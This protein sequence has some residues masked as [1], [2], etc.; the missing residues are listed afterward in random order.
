MTGLFRP[1]RA[2][3]APEGESEGTH[4]Q[5]APTADSDFYALRA[6][7]AKLTIPHSATVV[8][9]GGH[10]SWPALFS[11]LSGVQSILITD[12]GRVEALDIGR[13]PY[14][15]Q[16]VGRLKTD[17]LEDVIRF[18]RPNI[19]ILKNNRRLEPPESDIFHG[20]VL[21][22]GVDYKPLEEW[23]PDAARERSMKYV[24]GFYF[25]N[26]VG[27][28]NE[29]LHNLQY[30]RGIQVPVW[31]GSAAMSGCL[32]VMAAFAR[33]VTSGVTCKIFPCPLMS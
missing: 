26:K 11:A 25:G 27:V 17:A 10:G 7:V 19:E 33:P 29:Q 3:A 31:S 21:F 12:M 23:L 30:V 28:T 16:D 15:P 2:A 1:W 22:N 32:A 18:F 9:I 8:G 5:S 13:T 14:R 4:T 6:L 24:H 20:D